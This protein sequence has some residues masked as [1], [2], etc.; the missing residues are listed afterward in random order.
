MKILQDIRYWLNEYED[1]ESFC[2]KH[3][4]KKQGKIHFVLFQII[5]KELE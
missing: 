3:W 2:E 1:Y 5:H 4:V